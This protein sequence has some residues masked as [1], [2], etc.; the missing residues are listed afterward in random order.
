MLMK[1]VSAVEGVSLELDIA[2]TN[3]HLGIAEEISELVSELQVKCTLEMD[4]P[5]EVVQSKLHFHG[6]LV[7]SIGPDIPIG[8]PR[9]VIEGAIAGIPLVVPNHPGISGIVGDQA[10]FYNAG[11]EISLAAAITEALDSPMSLATRQELS[12]RVLNAHSSPG[13]FANWETDLT[14]AFMDWRRCVATDVHS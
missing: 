10:H 8:Q 14:K 1:A 9:S 4:V 13:V 12:A 2:T 6:A 7:Y 11:D 3:G 5:Y